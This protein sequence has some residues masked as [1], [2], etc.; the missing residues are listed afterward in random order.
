MDSG[1]AIEESIMEVPEKME[2]KVAYENEL[3]ST[4]QV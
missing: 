1:S 4:M 2:F 3:I